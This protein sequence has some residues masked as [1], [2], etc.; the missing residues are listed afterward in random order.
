MPIV[1]VYMISLFI[2]PQLWL[3]PFVGWQPDLFI[4][5][6][7]ILYVLFGRGR[8]LP[9]TYQDR[10]FLL[11]IVWIVLS[12]A[13]NGFRPH[14][15]TIII[16]Y[17]KYFILYIL[18]AATTKTVDRMQTVGLLLIVFAL[19][20]AVEGIQHIQNPAGLGWAGQALGWIDPGAASRGVLGRTRWINIFDGP[21]V[22]C[23]VFTTALPFAMQYIGGPFNISK[24]ILGGAIL[25]P[26]LLAIYYTGSR[27]GFLATLG[28]IG[29]Y[30]AI[31]LGI[32][33]LRVVIASVLVIIIFMFAPSHM[34]TMN[35]QSHSASHRVEMWGEGVEM[36][37]QNPI[38]GIGKGNFH[39]YTSMLIAHNSAIEIMGETGLV[40]LF[41][42]VGLVY[43]SL[44]NIVT[45]WKWETNEANRSYITGMGLSVIGYLIS[46]MFV[47]LEY[48]T[49]YLLLGLCAVP[50]KQLAEKVEFTR[51]DFGIIGSICIGWVLS[52]KIFVMTFSLH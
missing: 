45:Y 16:N 37:Q 34:T 3:E 15:P 1:I 5:G 52:I 20:L 51:K 14:S 43:M 21:G 19:I 50:G 4:Y 17:L 22:F 28:I 35:D 32:K 39:A 10:F 2:A 18:I 30:T 24:K 23:V 31:K 7:W 26:F 40:G 13:V 36:V 12:S 41:F 38:F 49:F 29:A 47:T 46:S 8:I 44:K 25:V 11:M 33:P 6:F 48:E 27:G 9:I 42:W